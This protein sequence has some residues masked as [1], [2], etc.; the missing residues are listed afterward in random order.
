MKRSA[1][2]AV[3]VVAGALLAG[4]GPDAPP[5]YAPD[6]TSPAQSSDAPA[7]HVGVT[8]IQIASIGL[9]DP[10][11]MEI[12]LLP[13]NA[14]G[15]RILDVPP[16]T[17]PMLVGWYRDS[18]VPGDPGPKPSIVE[19][20][21]NGNGMTGGFAQLDK[22]KVGAIV[23]IARTDGQTAEFK[24]TATD[25][26]K[27]ADYAKWEAKAFG[28]V[29]KPTVKLITCSGDYDKVHRNYLSNRVVTAELVSLKPTGP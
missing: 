29:T 17:A 5:H 10:Q 2:G 23:K 27:K 3:L 7:P 14:E 12:D 15:K 16:L 20:H 13:E 24:V 25:L 26:Y 22:V 18:A 8:R 4:C 21:I 11:T 6:L 19:S 9:D 1:A 28:D